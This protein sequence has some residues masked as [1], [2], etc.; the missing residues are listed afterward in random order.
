MRPVG[1]GLDPWELKPTI[2]FNNARG[3]TNKGEEAVDEQTGP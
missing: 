2:A 1:T 3:I